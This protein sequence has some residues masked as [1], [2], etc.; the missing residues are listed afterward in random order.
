[1]LFTEALAGWGGGGTSKR[2]IVSSMAGMI[3]LGAWTLRIRNLPSAITLGTTKSAR[4]MDRMDFIVPASTFFISKNFVTQSSGGGG[5]I[6]PCA[7]GA[8]GG[9]A[10]PALFCAVRLP[11][12]A[13]N[14]ISTAKRTILLA[15][16]FIAI[17]HFHRES[18]R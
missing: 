8:A 6:K 9:G 10:G 18:N 4:K 11:V 3:S 16:Y 17:L 15:G 7:G 14:V 5:G 1:M 13:S 12:I 2:A